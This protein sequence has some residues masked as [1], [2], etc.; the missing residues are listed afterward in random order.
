MVPT[1]AIQMMTKAGFRSLFWEELARMRKVD[2]A[3]THEQVYEMMESEYQREFGQRRYAS[4]R[5]FRDN[6]DR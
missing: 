6:R 1:R 2:D 4:F 3:I 5:S